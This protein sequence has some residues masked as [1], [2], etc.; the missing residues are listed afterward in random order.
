LGFATDIPSFDAV[1]AGTL[2]AKSLPATA[3]ALVLWAH[4]FGVQSGDSL[5]ISISG[6][7]GDVLSETVLLEKTQARAMRAIGKRLRAPLW[8]PGTYSGTATLT[9]AE[10]ILGQK[11]LSVEIIP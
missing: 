4:I 7:Q 3:P 5:D 6:P 8:P 11:S 9:R 2:N 10:K 1:K